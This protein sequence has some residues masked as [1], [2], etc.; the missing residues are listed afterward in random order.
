[1]FFFYLKN[2][3]SGVFGHRESSPSIEQELGLNSDPITVNIYQNLPDDD[4]KTQQY[5]AFPSD[6][7]KQPTDYLNT[8]PTQSTED[9]SYRSVPFGT[10]NSIVLISLFLHEKNFTFFFET[11]IDFDTNNNMY[12]NFPSNSSQANNIYTRPGAQ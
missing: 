1:M 12:Q 6:R 2:R 5:A 11:K 10:Q 3:S 4:S 9:M 8:F 7:E